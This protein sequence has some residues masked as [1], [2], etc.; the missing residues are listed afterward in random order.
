MS[1]RAHLF[2]GLAATLAL[3]PLCP[4]A[5]GKPDWA[6]PFLSLPSPAGDYIA[7]S[8]KWAVVYGEIEFSLAGAGAG[9]IQERHRFI[10]ENRTDHAL[11]FSTSLTY[12]ATIE[13]LNETAL[14]VE[15]TFLWHSINLKSSALEGTEREA[16]KLLFVS[17]EDI[18]GRH[19][20]VWEYALTKRFAF[21]PWCWVAIPDLYPAGQL[22][23]R[24]SPG[25]AGAGLT[26]DVTPG[27]SGG[28]PP[29]GVERGADGSLTVREVPALSRLDADLWFQ[30][31]PYALYPYILVVAGKDPAASWLG[32]T[33]KYR[34]EW[35]AREAE[36]D[37]QAVSSRAAGLTA[38]LKNP[39][40]KAAKLARFVQVDILYDDSNEKGLDGWFPLTPKDSL[41]S[42]K[43]DCKG[44][45]MLLQALLAAVGIESAPILLNNPGQYA[46]WGATPALSPINHVV[47]A[48]HLAE[49]G[50]PRPADLTEGPA[51]GWVYFDPTVE[52]ASLGAPMPGAEGLPA[53]FVG[54]AGDG[55]FIIH[56]RVPSSE[57]SDISIEVRPDSALGG[58]SYSVKAR[59]NGGSALI[60][61]V[62]HL[63]DSEKRQTEM[64]KAL[65]TVIQR[66]VVRRIGQEP[67]P[68][69]RPGEQVT[70]LEFASA[71]PFEEMSKS[72]LMAN[73]LAAAAVLKGLPNGIPARRTIPAEDRVVLH[74][75]WDARAL[76]FARA[77]TLDAELAL[78]LP[79]GLEWTLPAPRE[80]KR[81]WVLY[82]AA[83]S[84][85]GPSSWRARAHL[86]IP[87]G[88]WPSSQ[89]KECLQ[90]MDQIFMDLYQPLVLKKA[91]P[92]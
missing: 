19:R 10:L 28:V 6:K 37:R 46:D 75:P 77:M 1:L 69:D 92:K 61:T 85:E 31:E 73:P 66:I 5:L 52:A 65:G 80:E 18:P 23:Y 48:V 21:P 91:V 86:A 14:N 32:F 40:E 62:A 27:E 60:F 47:L 54:G 76:A 83:W 20:V 88:K 12:D 71:H 25:A 11:S 2:A 16:R 63:Y 39:F 74:P 22:V 35:A 38:G 82:T 29:P 7:Q 44:K 58:M 84:E 41:R 34:R 89:R 57:R 15:R 56:T 78:T 59:D 68:K 3:A 24:L 49:D 45:V 70:D 33:D 36:M 26:L 87:R 4:Q 51:K 8:D 81:E 43:A 13:E 42:M 30:P 55:R 90:A 17:V 67:P 79:P 9:A 64:A 50:A 53:L 72:T